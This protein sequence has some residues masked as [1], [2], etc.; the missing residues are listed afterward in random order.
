MAASAGGVTAMVVSEA[1]KGAVMVEPLTAG[2]LGSLVSITA[3][4]AVVHEAE[5]IV[6]GCGDPT[7]SASTSAS[8]TSRWG[9]WG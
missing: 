6:I 2:I 5:A 7:S 8:I 1:W 3:P 9:G 4:C